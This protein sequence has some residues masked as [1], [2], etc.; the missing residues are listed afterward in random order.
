MADSHGR[1]AL[2]EVVEVRRPAK[3]RGRQLEALLRW[4]G[5]DPATGVAWADEWK[6]VSARNFTEDV[7]AKA[8]RME[9][10]KYGKRPAQLRVEGERRSARLAGGGDGE[11]AG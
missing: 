8:R 5:V 9:A 10:A 6:P 7:L 11:G 3:R 1:H 2:Q 4:R